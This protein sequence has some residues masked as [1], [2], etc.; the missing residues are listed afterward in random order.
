M[1]DQWYR[2]QQSLHNQ[3]EVH[4]VNV[5]P[6]I[7]IHAV[8]ADGTSVNFDCM[9]MFG[10][11]FGNSLTFWR[12]HTLMGFTIFFTP[13]PRLMLKLARNILA[14]IKTIEDVDSQLTHQVG[15]HPRTTECSATRGLEVC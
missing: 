11:K 1:S 14:G 7:Q 3:I 10:C 12:I 2:W 6:H 8:T 4:Q 5:G 13:D 15:T 9:R